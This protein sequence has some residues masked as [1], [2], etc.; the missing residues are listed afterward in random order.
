MEGNN[1]LG[2]TLKQAR[3]AIPLTLTKLAEKSGV[4]Q[5]Y[6]ARVERGER[7]PSGHVLKKIASPLGFDEATLLCLAGFMDSPPRERENGHL[8][9]YVA[10][11]LSQEPV[12]TQRAVISILAIFKILAEAGES[13]QE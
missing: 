12:R 8:D 1:N 2:K 6:L 7:F 11:V 5:S 10:S 13:R 4:S 9:P 3:L